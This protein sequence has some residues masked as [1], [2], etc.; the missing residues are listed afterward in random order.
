MN[1]RAREV[2]LGLT[3][4]ALSPIAVLMALISKIESPAWYYGHVVAFGAWTAAGMVAGMA[5]IAR[6]SWA[7]ALLYALRWTVLAY[8]AAMFA[9]MAFSLGV[10]LLVPDG[11]QPRWLEAATI[12]VVLLTA[13]A[14]GALARSRRRA[15][16]A[17]PPNEEL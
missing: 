11:L 17:S 6:A 15:S 7:G 8:F 10:V 16:P 3:W 5:L 1:S 13:T 9:G 14:I 2:L 4:V 12:A